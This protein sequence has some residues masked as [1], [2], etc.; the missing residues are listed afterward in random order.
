M[1][2]KRPLSEIAL[3]PVRVEYRTLGNRTTVMTS[4]SGAIRGTRADLEG[5]TGAQSCTGHR[6]SS[7]RKPCRLGVTVGGRRETAGRSRRAFVPAEVSV[8]GV[9]DAG[10]VC[11][12]SLLATGTLSS[13]MCRIL[14][15]SPFL[16]NVWMVVCQLSCLELWLSFHEDWRMTDR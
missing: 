2:L 3:M 11:L 15:Y 14:Y 4:T 1:T 8:Y 10:A 5:W 16:L 7:V 13:H 9:A 12:G 6:L